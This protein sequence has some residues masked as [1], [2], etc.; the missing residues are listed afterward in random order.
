M[1]QEVAMTIGTRQ[2]GIGLALAAAVGFGAT[3][4]GAADKVAVGA[5]ATLNPTQGST[6]KGKVEFK[7]AKGGVLVTAHI[8]GLT[9]GT[10]GFHVHE[11]GDCSAPDGASAG[12]HFNPATKPHA[13]RDAKERHAGDLGNIEAN[14][15]GVAEV[16]FVDAQLK[17]DGP[18]GILGKGVIVHEKADDFTTQ[19][20]GNAG[21]RKACGVVESA[22]AEK[23]E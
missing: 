2:V 18:E 10:H 9:P 22:A 12:G 14:A 19:P 8:E 16:K 20:T 3:A 17:L 1:V 6:V 11:K 23:P 7:P 4:A 15:Q 21:G 13:A 5:Y